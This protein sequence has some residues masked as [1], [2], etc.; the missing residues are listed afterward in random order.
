MLSEEILIRCI[1]V[2]GFFDFDKVKWNTVVDEITVFSIENIDFENDYIVISMQLLSDIIKKLSLAGMK[3]DHMY[4]D[5]SN[6]DNYS[7]TPILGIHI[8]VDI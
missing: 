4:V 1:I 6:S 3:T 5:Y 8:C 2:A 7:E